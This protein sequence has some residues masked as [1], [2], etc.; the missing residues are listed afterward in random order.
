VSSY[1]QEGDI[2]F[3]WEV[4]DDGWITRS[5]EL[6]GAAL[7]PT[8]ATDLDEVMRARDE[9]GLS[10]VQA[11]EARYGVAPEKPIEDWDFPHEAIA[12]S[13]FDRQWRETRALLEAG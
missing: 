1:W 2:T 7:T 4:Q 8:A 12:A 5:V 3:L 13:E 6:S 9:R 10:A 11:I